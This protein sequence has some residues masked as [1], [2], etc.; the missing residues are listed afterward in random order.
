MIRR[1]TLDDLPDIC[2][3]VK[4]FNEDYYGRPLNM[5]KTVDTIHLL[6]SD[7]SVFVSPQGFIGG[8]AT[9]DLFRDDVALVELG[10]YATDRSGMALLDAFIQEGRD[11]EVDE[12]RMCTMHTSPASVGRALERRGFSITETSGQP[13]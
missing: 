12:I 13:A 5:T 9:A 10:W 4:Q 2:E 11:L 8:L 6:I 1:A 3:M 7:G